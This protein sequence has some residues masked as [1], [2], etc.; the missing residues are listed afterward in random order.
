MCQD[1]VKPNVFVSNRDPS[2][3]IPDSHDQYKR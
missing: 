3:S 1:N 2:R